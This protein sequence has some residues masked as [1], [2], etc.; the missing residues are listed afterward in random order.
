MAPKNRRKSFYAIGKQKNEAITLVN[1]DVTV[2]MHSTFFIKRALL[3]LWSNLFSSQNGNQMMRPHCPIFR[4]EKKLK[5]KVPISKLL[6][7]RQKSSSFEK[8]KT[9]IYDIFWKNRKFKFQNFWKREVSLFR[10]IESWW[11]KFVSS[12]VQIFEK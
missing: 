7:D 11:N 6:K 4:K 5:L 12:S 10:K 1:S 3:F 8:L 9:S 2:E